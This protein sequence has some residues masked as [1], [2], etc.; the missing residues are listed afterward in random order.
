M[1]TCSDLLLYRYPGG[2][3]SLTTEDLPRQAFRCSVAASHA[4]LFTSL[5]KGL[6]KKSDS[7][8]AC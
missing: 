8:A 4:V 2:E 5:C 1:Q 3:H 7:V 6:K